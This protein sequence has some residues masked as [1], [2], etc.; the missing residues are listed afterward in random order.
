MFISVLTSNCAL[1]LTS[2][3]HLICDDCLEDKCEDHQDCSV[4]YCVLQ[5]STVIST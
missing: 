4:L 1:L 2:H 3:R 5:L